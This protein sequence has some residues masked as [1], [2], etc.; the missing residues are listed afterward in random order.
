M[1]NKLNNFNCSLRHSAIFRNNPETFIFSEAE[2]A[3]L[4]YP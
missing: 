3:F 1:E 4:E 2:P